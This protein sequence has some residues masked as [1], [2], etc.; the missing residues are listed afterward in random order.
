MREWGEGDP[1]PADHPPL[2]DGED[3]TWLWSDDD[4]VYERRKFT[5]CQNS[6][7]S[8]SGLVLW[9]STMSWDDLLENYGP[10]REA[11]ASEARMIV[12]SWGEQR[13]GRLS[14]DP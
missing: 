2:V 7:G 13:V 3:V 5:H 6:D 8:D 10:L 12:E 1:V 4:L 9:G 11:T 14:D